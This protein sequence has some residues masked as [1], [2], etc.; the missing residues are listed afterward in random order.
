MLQCN[1]VGMKKAFT[2]IE[3]LVVIA[4]IG[5]LAAMI[6]VALTSARQKATEASAKVYSSSLRSALSEQSAGIWDFQN[7]DGVTA[8]DS[9]MV[10]TNDLTV[11]NPSMVSRDDGIINQ[12]LRVN[13]ISPYNGYLQIAD[14]PT[15]QLTDDLTIEFWIKPSTLSIRQNPLCK[16]YNG[17]FC[18]TAEVSG[19]LSYY[20]GCCANNLAPSTEY[21]GS[22]NPAT[23]PQSPGPPNTA[24][25]STGYT[26][27]YFGMSPAG[28]LQE[29][30]W[31]H[32]VLTRSTSSRTI[33]MYK[34]SK[35]ISTTAY[36]IIYTPISST[37]QVRVAGG[38]TNTFRGTIDEVR[39]YDSVAP[40]SMIEK[41]YLLGAIGHLH[42]IAQSNLGNIV[43][44]IKKDEFMKYKGTILF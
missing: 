4:I 31:T 33:K 8:K 25:C 20:H 18:F 40:V 6:L 3:L 30:T 27:R 43:D 9:S 26:S 42:P 15:L 24:A 34:N 7:Y 16:V 32:I 39:L 37:A 5:I 13:Q 2:L 36:S 12:G 19:A 35:L 38:Y 28:V 21:C 44:K 29:N 11:V 41:H 23:L 17:E 1:Q 10:G 14:N 22:T